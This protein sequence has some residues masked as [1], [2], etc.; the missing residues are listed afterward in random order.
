MLRKIFFWLHKW[1]GL[2]TGLV[3]LVVSITACINVFADELREFF[4]ADRFFSKVE[5]RPVMNF[6]D[7]RRNA[8]EALGPRY[9]IT[10]CEVYPEPG[11]NWIF[12]AT[13]TDP[14][15]IG[16]WNYYKYY[17]RVYINPYNGKVAYVEDTRNEFFQLVLNTHMNLL[18]GKRVGGL[19]TGIS[20]LCFLVLLL[21]GLFLWWPKK[22][23]IKNLRKGLL[24]KRNAGPKRRNYDL[25]NVLG[26][27]TLLPAMLICI[28]GL[29]FAF[30][31][32]DSSVQ[33]LVNGA[34]VVEKRAI[35]ISSPNE[36]YHPEAIDGAVAMLLKVHSQ[37]DVSSI[38]FREKS[39]DPLDV[40]VRLAEKRTHLFNWYYFDRNS[41]EL[42]LQYGHENVK[43]GEKFR[44][45]NFDLHTG[46]FSGLPTKLLAF[47]VSLICASL[48]VTGFIVWYNRTKGKSRRVPR[49]RILMKS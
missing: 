2:V 40:Q 29:V 41:G 23:S 6:S 48:P 4:Y 16:H 24:L 21:S 22:W 37:A 49:K 13:S 45:M 47:F 19:I 14:N 3:V 11:R 26:F 7:L 20:T 30:D 1:L 17:Y 46:A 28:T 9:K 33:Y 39:T 12:R 36:D 43:G 38:R 34:K 8:Q 44:S 32:A 25:H 31:W 5:D 18:L 27:Y 35:P 42:L 10:R 15:G